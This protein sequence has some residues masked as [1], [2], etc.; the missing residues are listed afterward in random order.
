MSY[1][2]TLIVPII[3]NTPHEEDLRE[4]MEKVS[5]DQSVNVIIVLCTKILL[6][7]PTRYPIQ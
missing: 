6:F 5:L 2:D 7:F 3:E 1:L 4:D